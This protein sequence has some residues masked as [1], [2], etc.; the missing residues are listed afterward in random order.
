MKRMQSLFPGVVVVGS[1][2]SVAYVSIPIQQQG[3]FPSV[4]DLAKGY[5]RGELR[6]MNA[7]IGG[8]PSPNTI[9]TRRQL[10]AHICSEVQRRLYEI[11]GFDMFYDDRGGVCGVALA[12]DGHVRCVVSRGVES[13][14]AREQYS[15]GPPDQSPIILYMNP[16]F[17]TMY[18][19]VILYI[20]SVISSQ[21]K[22]F[23]IVGRL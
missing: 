10:A 18:P 5:S 15:D 8:R 4:E 3:D 13:L 20:L 11:K 9:E 2:R 12:G 21:G 14:T 17:L 1:D 23:L 22:Q 7:N 6:E 19:S 16:I